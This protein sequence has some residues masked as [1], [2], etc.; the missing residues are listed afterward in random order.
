M[1]KSQKYNFEVL[2][3]FFKV[4]VVEKKRSELYSITTPKIWK[5]EKQYHLHIG[6]YRMKV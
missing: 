6:A 4:Q 1:D 3:F 2:G 5:H